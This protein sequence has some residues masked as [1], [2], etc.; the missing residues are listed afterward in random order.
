M[1]DADSDIT[2]SSLA[3]LSQGQDWRLHLAHDHPH[4]SLVWITRGQGVAL[5]DGMR[6]GVGAHN[7]LLIPAGSLFMLQMGRQCMGQ[8]VT[9]RAGTPLRMPE[10]PRHLRIRD[11]N[12]QAELASLIEIAAREQHQHRPLFHDALEAY[13]ALISVWLRRQI[14]ED[15][16]V[17]EKRN[18]AGRLSAR[19]CELIAQNYRKGLPMAEYATDLGVTPTHLSRAVKGAT[20]KTA[21]DLLTERVH[22]AARSLLYDTKEPAQNIARYLGFRSAAYFTRFMQHHSGLSPSKLRQP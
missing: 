18:A 19:Y 13:A 8:A 20:G 16:H 21:A 5:L 17:P 3:Q 6:R 9:I 12:Q 22:H 2:I 14:M 7:L 1:L 11:V 10:I 4:H 15:E